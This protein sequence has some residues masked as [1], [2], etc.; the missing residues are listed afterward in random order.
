MILYVLCVFFTFCSSILSAGAHVDPEPGKEIFNPT[1]MDPVYTIMGYGLCFLNSWF[2]PAGQAKNFLSRP[3]ICIPMFCV[4]GIYW[5][6]ILS[7]DAYGDPGLGKE[8]SN[9]ACLTRYTCCAFNKFVYLSFVS[10][11]IC[12]FYS[13]WLGPTRKSWKFPSSAT[14]PHS[15][16]P[17]V[18]Y[19]LAEYFYYRRIWG[20]GAGQGNFEFCLAW[21]GM[22]AVHS[23]VV[24]SL[25]ICHSWATTFVFFYSLWFESSRA[26][27]QIFFLGP[28]SAFLCSAC[29]VS[30]GWIFLLQARMGIRSWARNFEFCLAWL[31]THAV[32]PIIMLGFF[33]CNWWAAAFVFF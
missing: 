14:D 5:L 28:G 31:G 7:T 32:H 4:Y 24:L 18:R 13:L 33:N 16:V 8:I 25:C 26:K 3:R 2:D 17:C 21:P 29:T 27:L 9:F 19:L 20:S 12:F 22:H 15:Y 30:F 11:S 1:S 6:N 10:Y 23:K